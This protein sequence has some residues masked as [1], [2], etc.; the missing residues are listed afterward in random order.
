M[1]MIRKSSTKMNLLSPKYCLHAQQE[2]VVSTSWYVSPIF[3]LDHLTTNC[4]RALNLQHACLFLTIPPP[5]NSPTHTLFYSSFLIFSSF[6]FGFV[7]NII[8]FLP[9]L[10]LTPNTFCLHCLYI[11]ARR[12]HGKRQVILGAWNMGRG[13]GS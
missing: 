13:G 4:T 7:S 11:T 12:S 9:R 6:F 2:V 10:V 1:R 8:F 5:I 3:N